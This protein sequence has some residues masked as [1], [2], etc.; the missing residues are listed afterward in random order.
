MADIVKALYRCSFTIWNS[1][2]GIAMTLFTTSPKTAGGG[3]PYATVHTFYNAIAD[4]TVPIATVFFI[5]AL[6]KSVLSAPPGQQAQRFLQDAL[7][8][9]MILYIS[10]NM[11][12]IMGYLIDF[13]DGITGQISMTGGY[14]LSITGDLE[15]IMDECLKLPDFA[16]SG[17]WF[18]KFWSTV[19]CSLLFLLGGIILLFIMVASSLS[20][21]QWISKDFKAAYDP[22]V[23][24]DRDRTWS[25]RP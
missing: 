5:I 19:G 15:S 3:T 12:S 24:R 14:T 17:E 9:C 4:A 20:I 10:A 8:Y 16:I 6:Y 18:G 21:K 25:R 1:L 22:A 7:R 23:C 11:W 2:I 13:A